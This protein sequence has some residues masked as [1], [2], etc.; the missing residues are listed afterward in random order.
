MN[1]KRINFNN[2]KSNKFEEKNNLISIEK[3][4]IKNSLNNIDE[5]YI[6]NENNCNDNLNDISE[7]KLINLEKFDNSN[8]KEINNI[9]KKKLGLYKINPKQK[10]Y[11]IKTNNNDFKRIEENNI[12]SN[13]IKNFPRKN[14][15]NRDDFLIKKSNKNNEIYR[16]NNNNNKINNLENNIYHNELNL[17]IN[18]K[19]NKFNNIDLNNNYDKDEDKV[20][21]DN[22]IFNDIDYS[23]IG[24]RKNQE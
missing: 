2:I 3:N 1:E 17:N 8:K 5:N 12:I 7:N 24:Y 6:N 19:R 18:D 22:D 14:N 9:S 15:L 10:I 11:P 4:P 13:M 16:N 20:N 23:S 21:D